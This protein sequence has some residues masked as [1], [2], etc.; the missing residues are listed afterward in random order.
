[1]GYVDGWEKCGWVREI[2]PKLG[3]FEKDQEIA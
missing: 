3:S 2:R 1:M